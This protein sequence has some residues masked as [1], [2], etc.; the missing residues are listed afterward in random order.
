M[1][2]GLRGKHAIVTGGSSP[3]IGKAIPR[4]LAREGVDTVIVARTKAEDLE[5]RDFTEDSPR[6]N[7]IGRMVNAAE[8]AYLTVRLA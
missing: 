8:I 2:V 3:G 5:K 6:G 1:D 4:G 7:A